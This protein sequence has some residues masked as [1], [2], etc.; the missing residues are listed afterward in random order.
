MLYALVHN[1]QIQVGPRTWNRSFFLDYLEAQQLDPT[2]L[3]RAEPFEPTITVDWKLL[4]VSNVVTP[5]HDSTYE[6][7]VGP[8]W[9]IHEDHITGLYTKTDIPL[10]TIKGTLKNK[11]A[12]NR[13]S[14]ETGNLDFEFADGQTVS[15][16]TEREERMIYL[17]TL[18][19][20]PDGMTVPFKFKNGKFRQ[21]VTKTDLQA[22]VGAGMMHIAGVFEWESAKVSEIE[23]AETIGE[24]KLVELRHPVQIAAESERRGPRNAGTTD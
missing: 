11:V 21:G 12:A 19:A 14:V 20:L 24:L 22:I 5:E 10:D 15:I 7:L 23:A 17:N 2:D 16:Y 9:T 8:F 4:T 13:Y 6:Q 3:P 18:L 1:N